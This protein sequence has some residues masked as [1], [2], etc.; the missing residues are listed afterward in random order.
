MGCLLAAPGMEESQVYGGGVKAPFM[1]PTLAPPQPAELYLRP[2]PSGAL[3]DTPDAH[4]QHTV[5]A[6]ELPLWT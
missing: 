5:M 1:P 3:C 2:S 6:T 4:S